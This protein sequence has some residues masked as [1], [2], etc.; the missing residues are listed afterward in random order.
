[1]KFKIR[2]VQNC[3]WIVGRMFKIVRLLCV[4]RVSMRLEGAAAFVLACTLMFRAILAL[5][6][7]RRHAIS[8]SW[9]SI[10]G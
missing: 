2:I 8:C 5:D 10:Q 4:I 6:L 7:L 9:V 3:Q 1:M